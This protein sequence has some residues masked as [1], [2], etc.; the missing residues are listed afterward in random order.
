MKVMI[1]DDEATGRN[2]LDALL[3]MLDFEVHTASNASQAIDVAMKVPLDV[4]IIDWML[5]EKTDG[6]GVADAVHTI[7]PAAQIVIISGQLDVGLRMQATQYKSLA[8]P[9]ELAELLALLPDRDDP[10]GFQ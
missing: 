1:V 5:G 4:A 8:K 10:Y 3:S 2:S 7:H 9:F 6:L